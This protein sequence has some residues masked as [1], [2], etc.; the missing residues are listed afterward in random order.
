MMYKSV[1]SGFMSCVTGF[2]FVPLCQCSLCGRR[3]VV[4]MLFIII[5]QLVLFIVFLFVRLILKG[6]C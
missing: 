1:D 2:I 3:G 4:V 6:D 5:L